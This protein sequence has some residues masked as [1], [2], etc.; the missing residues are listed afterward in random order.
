MQGWASCSFSRGYPAHGTG[1]GRTR[2][3]RSAAPSVLTFLIRKKN[4]V[5]LVEAV[6]LWSARL[7]DP[8]DSRRG[9]V[10]TACVARGSGVVYTLLRAFSTGLDAPEFTS[11][12]GAGW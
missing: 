12:V 10:W 4:L 9:V 11:S 8:C 5:V 7:K 1:R 3:S 6:D 2:R